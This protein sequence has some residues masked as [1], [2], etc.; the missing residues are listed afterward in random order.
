[1]KKEIRPLTL[2][3]KEAGDLSVFL[4][5]VSIR[6]LSHDKTLSLYHAKDK[7]ENHK[8]SKETADWI[9]KLSTQETNEHLDGILQETTFH[10]PDPDR[11]DMMNAYGKLMD[12]V[13]NNTVFEEV[14]N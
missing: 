4:L 14:M 12:Y 11:T 8:F 13:E 10:V 3:P 5:Q 2:T 9:N 1:M 6:L 7:E